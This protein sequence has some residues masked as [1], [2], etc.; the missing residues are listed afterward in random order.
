MRHVEHHPQVPWITNTTL[1]G[2]VLWRCVG[3]GYCFLCENSPLKDGFIFMRKKRRR[4]TFPREA[5]GLQFFI[6]NVDWSSVRCAFIQAMK[7]ACCD[8]IILF[9]SMSA[10]SNQFWAEEGW[11]H[12]WCLS[13]WS[14]RVRTRVRRHC[15]SVCVRVCAHSW[16]VCFCC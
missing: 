7:D 16:F 5:C 6:W 2:I 12:Y 4:K 1:M 11:G 8:L 10:M 13:Y 9:S 3:E 14:R 15:L